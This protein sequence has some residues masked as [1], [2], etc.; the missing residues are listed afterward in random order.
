MQTKQDGVRMASEAIASYGQQV[1]ELEQEGMAIEMSFEQAKQQFDAALAQLAAFLLPSCAPD[2]LQGAA[3]ELGANHLPQRMNQYHQQ[4]AQSAARL[5]QID[6]D[7]RYTQRSQMLHPTDGTISRRMNELKGYAAPLQQSLSRFEDEDYQWL[8]ANGFQNRDQESGFRKFWKAVT[9]VS[10]KEGK[11]WE[12][13]QARLGHE[14]FAA[15]CAE[16]E[17]LLGQ[18][19]ALRG[20]L[21]QLEAQKAE[22]FALLDE[23]IRHEAWVN[24]FEKTATEALR[25]DLVEYLRAQDWNQFHRYI[26]PAGRTFAA[27]CHA[28]VHKAKYY[29]QMLTYLQRETQDRKHRIASI[30]SVRRKWAHRPHGYLTGDKTKWLRTVPA[31]KRKG[32]A[33]RVRWVHNMH[34][35]IH[36]FDDYDDYGY[37]MGYGYFFAYDAFNVWS[38]EPMPHE[39]FAREVLPEL[40][41]F[42][43][44]TGQDGID[45]GAYREAASEGQAA[46]EEMNQQE[47]EAEEAAVAALAAEE[48]LEA[49]QEMA[50]AS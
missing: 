30:D 45:K 5:K 42:R 37:A 7:P 26:R 21:G 13:L 23:R 18:M 10:H 49:E 4:Q 43:E 17:Q 46:E 34:R 28:L 24:E 35:G 8:F 25:K 9:L 19:H 22:I 40:A 33:K 1:A 14:S 27:Q 50:D 6:V 29:R 3:T 15:C 44:A 31:M 2:V 32:T 12:R 20:E 16:H 11:A 48:A 36:D 41:E 39:G 47:L 38:E